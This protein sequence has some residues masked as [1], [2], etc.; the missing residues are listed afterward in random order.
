MLSF[1]KWKVVYIFL[2]VSVC[3][4]KIMCWFISIFNSSNYFG[5]LAVKLELY[6]GCCSFTYYKHASP[7]IILNCCLEF[8]SCGRL[9]L[10]FFFMLWTKKKSFQIFFCFILCFRIISDKRFLFS[11]SN[12]IEDVSSVVLQEKVFSEGK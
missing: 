6:C 9:F 8:V 2:F 4:L 1:E 10:Q 7:R 5:Y 3:I 12:A 11:G